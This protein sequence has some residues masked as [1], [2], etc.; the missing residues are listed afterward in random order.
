MPAREAWGLDIGQTGIH[1]VRIKRLKGGEAQI[2]DA[3]FQSLDAQLDD[4]AYDE[5]VA[6]AL[7]RFAS[8]KKVGRTPVVASL[9]GF[10]TLFRDFPLPL[11]GGGRMKEI[12]SYEARQ[13][14]PY[15]LEEVIWDYHI[16]RRDEESGEVGIALLC[17]R[18]DIVEKLIF[19]LDS[20]KLNIDALQVGPVALVNYIEFDCPPEG[21]ALLLDT[22]ARGT[23]FVVLNEG[24]FWLRSI[25]ISGSDFTKS[26]MSKFTIPFE[27]AEELK[28]E[29][30]DSKQGDRV[31][32]VLEPQLRNLCGEVQR[33][34]GYYRSLFRGVTLKE[35]ICAG[36]SFNLAGIDQFVADNVGLP[37]RTMALP[38]QIKVSAAAEA[39]LSGN[40][41]NLGT[42]VGLALQGVGLAGVDINLLPHE[43]Q[44]RKMVAAK[45]KWALAAVGMVFLAVLMN[46]LFA[47][48]NS[49]KFDV[50]VN[51]AQDA[52][53]LVD[54]ATAEFKA[55]ESKF[56]EETARN[57]ALSTKVRP[58]RGYL[59]EVM[60]ACLKPIEKVNFDSRRR[61]ANEAQKPEAFDLLK[62]QV[63]EKFT[64]FDQKDA[65]LMGELDKRVKRRVDWEYDR[66]GRIF[67][68]NTECKILRATK[69][70][71]KDREEYFWL[72]DGED[73]AEIEAKDFEVVVETVQVSAP[74]KK[75]EKV[76]E[77][78]KGAKKGSKK[79]AAPKAAP[80]KE[81]KRKVRMD[82]V[83]VNL[84][85]I[86]VSSKAPEIFALKQ[87]FRDIPGVYVMG[88][89]WFARKMNAVNKLRL[90][91]VE[92]PRR[93]TFGETREDKKKRL[94]VK[95]DSADE[96]VIEWSAKFY[97][98]PKAWPESVTNL[99]PE[100][101]E[102]VGGL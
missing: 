5:K 50:E 2:T 67:A 3:F 38:E 95:F 26:L 43:R 52:V 97:Y 13:L 20:A 8:E 92:Q 84:S 101:A 94:E 61:E 15:P 28:F 14:I 53:T 93:A 39:V 36:G 11:V 9:P 86:M 62:K 48:G 12:V 73:S 85:G 57:R 99:I 70:K 98:V 23:D 19:T 16:L 102:A 60:A 37:T 74:L 42:A 4:P 77:D 27:K 81:V 56:P 88:A 22:G 54:K 45:F 40:V 69:Y 25:G 41:Q 10:T 6:D 63:L 78:K 32:R 29:I 65:E 59:V 72:P 47:R 55:I 24:S 68:N 100:E 89:E 90:P 31:F 34:I 51:L 33:S 83:A 35:V 87:A 49:G 17:C 96:E 76:K 91:T 71:H 30:K 46:A 7:A 1:A 79:A 82:I 64:D 58:T 80:K 21:S 18:R 44:M 75:E 66:K